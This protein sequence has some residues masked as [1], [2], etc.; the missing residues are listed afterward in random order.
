MKRLHFNFHP[1][2]CR[3]KPI[4]SPQGKVDLVS[5]RSENL[6]EGKSHNTNAWKFIACILYSAF[7]GASKDKKNKQNK[8]ITIG[9]RRFKWTTRKEKDSF[10]NKGWFWVLL[11][12]DLTRELKV[13]IQNSG[14]SVGYVN[15]ATRRWLLFLVTILQCHTWI[16]CFFFENTG[17]LQDGK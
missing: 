10:I 4:F 11:N 14:G 15:M 17:L 16:Y 1:S 7:G 5:F 8:K 12:Q 3:E 6:S 2:N 9:R 13:E